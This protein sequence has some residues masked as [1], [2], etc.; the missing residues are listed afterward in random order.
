MVGHCL[1]LDC[2]TLRAKHDHGAMDHFHVL[3]QPEVAAEAQ[4]AEQAV[5]F[6]AQVFP[7]LLHL[8]LRL[9]RL[10]N[11]SLLSLGELGKHGLILA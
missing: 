8:N 7:S 4:V 6:E 10:R 2:F 9:G 1:L 3:L 5:L 11:S